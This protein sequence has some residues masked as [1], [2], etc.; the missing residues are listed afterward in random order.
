MISTLATCHE[1]PTRSSL[2]TVNSSSQGAT[3]LCSGSSRRFKLGRDDVESWRKLIDATV[4]LCQTPATIFDV[5]GAQVIAR[6][7]S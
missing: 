3:L 4:R 2:V 6:T 5:D 7:T 1:V